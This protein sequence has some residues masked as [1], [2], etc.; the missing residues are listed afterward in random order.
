MLPDGMKIL[1]SVTR[2]I[3][4]KS[5]SLYRIRHLSPDATVAAAIFEEAR[6]RGIGE[7][8]EALRQVVELTNEPK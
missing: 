4:W 8:G 2:H 1:W 5:K 6:N 7:A 3:R